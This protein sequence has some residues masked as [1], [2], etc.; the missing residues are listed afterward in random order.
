MPR[1]PSAIQEPATPQSEEVD[2]AT[3]QRTADM[4]RLLAELKVLQARVVA[5]R[6]LFDASEIEQALDEVHG[7]C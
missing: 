2:P 1:K 6:G 4:L 3:A 7:H 5:R